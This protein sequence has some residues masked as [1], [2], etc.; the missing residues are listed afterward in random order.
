M[1]LTPNELDYKDFKAFLFLYAARA[2]FNVS[3]EENDI[4]VEIVSEKRLKELKKL[5]DS[6]SDYEVIQLI[7]EL[8]DK[9]LMTDATKDRLLEEIMDLFKSDDD[10]SINER[11]IFRALKRIL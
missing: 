10:F 1:S 4:L 2:D 7:M 11:N 5:S 8:K 6:M 9:Y 3:E